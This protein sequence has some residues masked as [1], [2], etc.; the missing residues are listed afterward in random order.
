LYITQVNSFE[1]AVMRILIKRHKP[2]SISYL[3]EGF[4][5]NSEDF[6]LEAIGNLF[7]SGY[8]L[9]PYLEKK[10]HITYNNEKR[11]EI[12]KILDPLPQRV[13]ETGELPET[14]EKMKHALPVNE[15]KTSNNKRWHY[16]IS[17]QQH[18]SKIALGISVLVIGIVSVFSSTISTA[19]VYQ[20]FGL[21]GSHYNH[22][23]PYATG[24]S[25][26]IRR[27]HALFNPQ[28][29]RTEESVN[30]NILSLRNSLPNCNV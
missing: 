1:I 8:I 29:W 20:N 9:Y 14:N 6:V 19:D 13:V 5:N 4:P 7:K 21:F 27:N 12:L 16:Y 15:K 24:I 30:N 17:T 25:E 18:G 11:K 2:V 23:V 10:D 22:N 28:Y 26:N 3:A